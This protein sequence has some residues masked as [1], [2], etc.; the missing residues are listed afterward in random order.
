MKRIEA[1]R[2]VRTDRRK[3]VLDRALERLLDFARP[4]GLELVPFGSYAKGR[5]RS[6]SDLDLAIPGIVSEE[7]RRRLEREAERVEADE[8]VQI[9]LMFESEIPTYFTELRDALSAYRSSACP[10]RRETRPRSKR[11]PQTCPE[12]YATIDQSSE[13]P[14]Q[15]AK[16][17][18]DRISFD[19]GRGGRTY[20]K[21]LDELKD[22]RDANVDNEH[23][24]EE[25]TPALALIVH[26]LYNGTERILEDIA[27]IADDF[28][29]SGKSSH[30]DLIDMMA[31][32]T[33]LRPAVL[34]PELRAI[35]HDL[36]KFRH[37]VRHSYGNPL[38]T[39]KVMEK[40]E[41]FRRTFWP[42]FRGSLERVLTHLENAPRSGNEKSP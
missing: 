29:Q 30:A 42:G 24:P 36:R 9:D 15:E 22:G 26:N 39:R 13:S 21:I 25:L 12:G 1:I 32:K 16:K 3:A 18:L 6:Q 37:V 5:V 2:Q 11:E 10:G 31:A 33:P 4:L 38:A 7:S 23:E 20:R 17:K 19:L 41:S 14:L 35:L 34:T 40:F 28:D 8:G 27:K